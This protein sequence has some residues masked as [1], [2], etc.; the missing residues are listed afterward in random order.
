MSSQGPWQTHQSQ[1]GVEISDTRHVFGRGDTLVEKDG[2][3]TGT[4]QDMTMDVT[5]PVYTIA[6]T[7][8]L[9]W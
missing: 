8:F 6:I 4:S 1:T 2:E 7:A 9:G 3:C 5:F